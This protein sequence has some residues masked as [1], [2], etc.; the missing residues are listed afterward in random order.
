MTCYPPYWYHV[1][2]T[3]Q[4]LGQL[5]P[6]TDTY[7]QLVAMGE[8]HF[9]KDDM[10]A[11]GLANQAAIESYL[12]NPQAPLTAKR[13]MTYS[14]GVWQANLVCARILQQSGETKAAEE[15]I[16]SNL[17]V[18]LER[19]QSLTS[20]VALYRESGDTQKLLA[21]LNDPE[22]VQDLPAV[23]LLQSAAH[24][25]VRRLPPAA[26]HQLVTSLYAYDQP[27][28]GRP[29]VVCLAAPTWGLEG[30]DTALVTATRVPPQ[31]RG[32]ANN[33]LTQLMFSAPRGAPLG[34]DG[35]PELVFEVQ[36]EA[37]EPI[38]LHLKRMA[39]SPEMLEHVE[40][41]AGRGQET[42]EP[43][44]RSPA[45]LSATRRRTTFVITN[46]EFQKRTIA[47]WN[48][49]ADTPLPDAPVLVDQQPKAAPSK[50]SSAATVTIE[51][52]TPVISGDQEEHDTKPEKSAIPA[53]EQPAKK[54]AL[55]VPLPLFR[56][57]NPVA[58]GQD[59]EPE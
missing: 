32:I 22:T 53:S 56:G 30:A 9:R 14:T 47:L 42:R 40:A 46:V 5:V 8:G 59:I 15:A 18:D 19:S 39:W 2:R 21:Q 31:T 16:L 52:V 20:L 26:F 50:K 24:L 17:D 6:A 48:P 23:L 13:A 36:Y 12:Q 3:Q 25:G 7:R 1:A 58:I 35:E 28:F 51:T 34:A 33:G 27:A 4:A 29:Q 41:Q 44:S 57:S 43:W 11:A 45:T 10:L 55:T 54:P 37:A 38:R 49:S